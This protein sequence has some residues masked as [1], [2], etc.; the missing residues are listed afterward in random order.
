VRK[1]LFTCVVYTKKT[2]NI[3]RQIDANTAAEYLFI[4]LF[5]YLVES[6]AAVLISICLKM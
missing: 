5:I 6:S 4:Y 2:Y 3:L 1:A